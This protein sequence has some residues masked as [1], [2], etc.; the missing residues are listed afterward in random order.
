MS[1]LAVPPSAVMYF[2]QS[3]SRRG[4]SS[5]VAE[6]SF[7]NSEPVGRGTQPDKN[8]SGFVDANWDGDVNGRRSTRGFCF[9]AGSTAISW[10]TKK[11]SIV[12]LSSCE[13]EYVAATMATQ[14]CLWLR[15]FI[16]EMCY[17]RMLNCRKYLL[18]S[19][20]QT[21]LLRHLTK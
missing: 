12:A 5:G 15:R 9:I 1:M 2:N 19:K 21:Y 11:Q 17:R 3:G 18:M 14:E 8:P 7:N 10:C 13:A 16:Q 4:V 6:P 20:L